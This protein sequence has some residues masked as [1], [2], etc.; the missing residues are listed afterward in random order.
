MLMKIASLHAFECLN[1][2]YYDSGQRKNVILNYFN[3]KMV[4]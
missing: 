2:D 3:I 4:N 1:Q